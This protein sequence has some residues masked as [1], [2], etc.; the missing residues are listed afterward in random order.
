MPEDKKSQGVGVLGSLGGLAVVVL[1]SFV[2]VGSY[3]ADVDT[4]KKS[5]EKIDAQNQIQEQ[6]ITKL[7]TCYDNVREMLVEMKSD[8]K[9]I[10][11]LAQE[12]Q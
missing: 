10:K 4:L 8:I 9:D 12:K 2:F 7:E 1:S 11:K 5:T 3:K 6:R